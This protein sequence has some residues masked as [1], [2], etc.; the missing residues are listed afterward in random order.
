MFMHA[1]GFACLTSAK[2]PYWFDLAIYIYPVGVREK[3]I[4]LGSAPEGRIAMTR[5]FFDGFLAVVLI[6]VL[7][8]EQVQPVT[9]FPSHSVQQQDGST[10]TPTETSVD[11][12]VPT[13]ATTT[14]EATLAETETVGPA[15]ETPDVTLTPTPTAAENT[16]I[17][18]SSDTPATPETTAQA[19]SVELI[20]ETDPA[21]A[22]HSGKVQLS[23]EVRGLNEFEPEGYAIR[24]SLPDGLTPQSSSGAEGETNGNIL[25]LPLKELSGRL[26]LLVQEDFP[27]P[28]VISAVVLQKDSEVTKAEYV[29]E[30]APGQSVDQRGGVAAG[31]DDRVRVTFPADALDDVSTV[32]IRNPAPEQL[33]DS[34]PSPLVFEVVAQNAVTK[35]VKHKF[36]KALQFAVTYDPAAFGQVRAEALTLLWYNEEFQE[37]D[38]IISRVDPETHVIHAAVNHLSL[39]AVGTNDIDAARPPFLENFQTGG[40][41]GAVTYS[42]PIQLPAGP[43]GLQPTLSL[44]YNS[45]VVDESTSHTQA[46]WVG[47]GWCRWK[48]GGSPA[49]STAHPTFSMTI[50]STSA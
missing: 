18:A 44:D 5:K 29:L 49:T 37:W 28:F 38:P 26:D 39:F 9:A 11:T 40:Y 48:R 22:P 42:I 33:P 16:Q 35:E 45:Q 8:L 23:W 6:A 12:P 30:K 25:T 24:F 10:P 32:W 27:G 2:I 7:F 34:I 17:P 1:P 13:E 50:P 36:S 31:L 3:Q 46:S 41:S 47:M 15:T 19:E 21:F 20:L 4:G 43:G 14:P